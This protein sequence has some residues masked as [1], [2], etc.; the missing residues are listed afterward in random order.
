[1]RQLSV[2][3]LCVCFLFIYLQYLYWKKYLHQER[4]KLELIFWYSF[5]LSYN[6]GRKTFSIKYCVNVDILCLTYFYLNYLIFFEL[7]PSIESYICETKPKIAIF[8]Q[9]TFFPVR[10]HVNHPKMSPYESYSFF[11]RTKPI[12]FRL[13]TY[14]KTP[15]LQPPSS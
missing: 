8:L 2:I 12:N 3:L 5:S 9:E 10:E 7:K 14:I 11:T 13:K 1:M 6:S 15:T 4:T